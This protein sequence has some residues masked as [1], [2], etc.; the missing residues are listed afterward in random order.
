MSDIDGL[1]VGETDKAF[2]IR[3]DEIEEWVPKSAIKNP[4]ISQ[5]NTSQK[6]L[7]DN[8]ILKKL[9]LIS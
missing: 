3:F 7:I 4:S 1:I 5:K 8:W 2:L 9:H 6:F